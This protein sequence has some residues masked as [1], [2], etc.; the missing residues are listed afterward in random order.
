[1]HLDYDLGQKIWCNDNS[2]DI[3]DEIMKDGN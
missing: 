3:K 2:K 1:M